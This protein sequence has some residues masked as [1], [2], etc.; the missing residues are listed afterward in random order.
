MPR[1]YNM[2]KWAHEREPIPA[3]A[4][5]VDRRT[6]WGNPFIMRRERDRDAVC[7]QFAT[8]ARERVAREPRWL[9]PLRGKDLACWC[10]PKRCHAETLLELAN[11]EKGGDEIG[12]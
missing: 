4:V 3:D 7:E 8:Y 6:P 12:R 10:W 11:A 2:R 9:A 5:R 1:I